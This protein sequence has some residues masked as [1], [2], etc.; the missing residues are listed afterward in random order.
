MKAGLPPVSAVATADS[1]LG[2]PLLDGTQFSAPLLGRAQTMKTAYP[3]QDL[4]G[5]PISTCGMHSIDDDD[6]IAKSSLTNER[7]EP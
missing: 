5:N 4:S 2:S 7:N 1:Q 6:W 3:K